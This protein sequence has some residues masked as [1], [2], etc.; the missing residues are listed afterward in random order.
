MPVQ[1]GVELRPSQLALADGTQELG[2]VEVA[3]AS[4]SKLHQDQI[5]PIHRLPNEILSSIFCLAQRA[6]YAHHVRDLL[7]LSSVCHHWREIALGCPRLWTRFRPL[8]RSLF[9]LFLER[10]KEAPL[11]IEF[12]NHGH[13]SEATFQEYLTLVYPHVHRWRTFQLR[14]SVN[15]EI[16]SSILLGPFPLLEILTLDCKLRRWDWAVSAPAGPS[17]APQLG[18]LRLRDTYIPFTHPIYSN[19]TDL[20]LT[21]IQFSEMQGLFHVLE[22][23]PL[24][25]RLH[26]ESLAFFSPIPFESIHPPPPLVQLPQLQFLHIIHMATPQA[27]RA[28]LSCLVAPPST[29]MVF[30]AVPYLEDDLSA[31][32]P[33]GDH[34]QTSLPTLSSAFALRVG[35]STSGCNV[36]GYTSR[37]E[38]SFE[39]QL[40]LHAATAR[41]VLPRIFSGLGTLLPT[42]SLQFFFLHDA[43]SYISAIVPALADFLARHPDI[44]HLAFEECHDSITSILLNTSICPRLHSLR[45]EKCPLSPENLLEI[46]GLRMRPENSGLEPRGELDRL[47]IRGCPQFEPILTSLR[48]RVTVKYDED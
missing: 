46:V 40:L 15:A 11:D 23:S 42:P 39:L 2:P 38:V 5:H 48:G 27:L 32:L 9:D 16:L 34:I 26:L 12:E 3:A 33:L 22:A 28:T 43:N 45:I 14:H 29:R 24:L 1:P 13:R 8:Q 10:S 41:Q 31:F 30:A 20:S 36:R 4:D 44:M 18:V 21:R 25:K 37:H 19:L 17:H 47:E 35:T 7:N 6:D